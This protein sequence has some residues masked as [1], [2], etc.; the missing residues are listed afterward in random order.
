MAAPPLFRGG[1][2]SSLTAALSVAVGEC[3]F[4]GVEGEPGLKISESHTSDN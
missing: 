4:I 2:Q 1:S 3:K